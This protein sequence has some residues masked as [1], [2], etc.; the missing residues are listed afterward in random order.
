MQPFERPM[1]CL[2]ADYKLAHSLGLVGLHAEGERELRL[3]LPHLLP[4]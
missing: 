4:A 1:G 3:A 2:G